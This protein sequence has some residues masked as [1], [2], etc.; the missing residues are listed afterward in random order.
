MAREIPFS[1]IQ[2]TIY[3]TVKSIR[4]KGENKPE[5]YDHAINGTISG[6]MAAFIT[7]PIDVVKTQM[8]TD[9]TTNPLTL[10][11]TVKMM[12][13]ESGFGAFFK[14]W[15]VRSLNIAISSVIFFSAYE[16]SKKFLNTKFNSSYK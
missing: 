13:K 1:S 3:E 12:Y 15:H 8:M 9:R 10:T 11:E 16:N 14:G 5:Y 4:H 7:T 2:M 6:S